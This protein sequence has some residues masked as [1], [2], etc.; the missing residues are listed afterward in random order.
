[1]RALAALLLLLACGCSGPI[2]PK[3]P[4]PTTFEGAWAEER[5]RYTRSFQLYDELD[6]V[7][8]ATATY[9]APSVREARVNR[10]AEW[11]GMQPAEREA[12]LASEREAAA[13]SEEFLLAF[14]TSDRPANDLASRRGTWR[15]ALLVQ[16]DGEVEGLPVK[17]E[18]VR[19]DPTVRALYPYVT[20]FDQ[21]YRIRFPRLTGPRPL[22]ELPFVLRIAGAKGRVEMRWQPGPAP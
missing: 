21:L 13:S 5:D 14:F 10:L 19:T 16:A 3:Q 18:T 1:M 6:D 17:V 12:L 7:A 11:K 9:Q 20:D 2:L 15:I 4:R 8:F 22:A